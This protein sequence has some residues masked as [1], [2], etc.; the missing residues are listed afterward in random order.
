MN[1]CSYLSSKNSWTG[2]I[3]YCW[4]LSVFENFPIVSLGAK[5]FW[6][7]EAVDKC[8]D[9]IFSSN[10]WN[11]LLTITLYLRIH[12]PKM[13]RLQYAASPTILYLFRKLKENY[14]KVH[15]LINPTMIQFNFTQQYY[16]FKAAWKEMYNF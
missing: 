7:N 15:K 13:L 12:I 11:I 16:N 4:Y 2:Y 14:L 3:L 9:F 8:A 1:T 10:L 6:I 5:W